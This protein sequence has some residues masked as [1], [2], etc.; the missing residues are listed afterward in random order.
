MRAI[1]VP[2]H[3][4][5]VIIAV[6]RCAVA[7]REGEEPGTTPGRAGEGAGYGGEARIGRALPVEPVWCDGDG[8]ALAIE[9]RLRGWAIANAS[10]PS[11]RTRSRSTKLYRNTGLPLR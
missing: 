9:S 4:S 7:S 3:T 11:Q 8:V 10:G 6:R 2:T 5:L 1:A